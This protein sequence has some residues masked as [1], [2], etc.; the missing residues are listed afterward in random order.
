MILPQLHQGFGH[1]FITSVDS[2]LGPADPALGEEH[3]E[4]SGSR[5]VGN[6]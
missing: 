5:G 3:E 4:L 6:V 2:L 1:A